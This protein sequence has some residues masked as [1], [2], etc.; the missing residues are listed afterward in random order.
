MQ[1]GM[2]NPVLL[3]EIQ[4][5]GG[6]LG[7]RCHFTQGTAASRNETCYFIMQAR[8]CTS[9][10]CRNTAKVSGTETQAN[11]RWTER[12]WEHVLCSDESI[13][14]PVSKQTSGSQNSSSRLLTECECPLSYLTLGSLQ[15]I[16]VHIFIGFYS[17]WPP[18]SNP[19]QCEVSVFCPGTLRETVTLESMDQMI[20]SHFHPDCY[21]WTS[22]CVVLQGVSVHRACVAEEYI[23]I[24]HRNVLPW[25]SNYLKG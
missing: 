25:F 19:G 10:L 21:Q 2:R 1:H 11:V 15:R 13:F 24:L 4:P 23:G 17:G 12:Q 3:W 20:H 8:G 5:L 14:H 16:M 7:N 6:T 22:A 9:S 18:S